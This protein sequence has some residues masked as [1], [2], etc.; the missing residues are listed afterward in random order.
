MC[1]ITKGTNLGDVQLHVVRHVLQRLVKL[2]RGEF[3]RQ[4]DCVEDLQHV[5]CGTRLGLV[6]RRRE[7]FTSE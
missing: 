7:P 5:E 1:E 4:S 2:V 3:T 6:N